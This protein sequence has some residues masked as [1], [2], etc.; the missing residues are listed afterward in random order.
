MV[1]LPQ[2]MSHAFLTKSV[3]AMSAHAAGYPLAT[4]AST[5][6]YASLQQA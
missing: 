5:Q 2:R 1:T 3:Q 4:F 6:A